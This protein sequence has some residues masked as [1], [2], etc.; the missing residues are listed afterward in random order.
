MSRNRSVNDVLEAVF[1][2][3]ASAPEALTFAR[4]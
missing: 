4:Q 3:D 1:A 2:R